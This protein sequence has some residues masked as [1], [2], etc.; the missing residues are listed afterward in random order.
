MATEMFLLYLFTRLDN[1]KEIS[2]VFLVICAV[3]LVGSF[4]VM[5]INNPDQ[6][7]SRSE[8]RDHE[9]AKRMFNSMKPWFFALLF[10]V[11]FVPNQKAAM[12]IVAGTGVIEAAKTDT[13]QRIATK[14]VGVVEKYLDEMLNDTKKDDKK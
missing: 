7:Y 13:A 8:K 3:L 12:F 2:G 1:I 14:S 4:I 11:M 6:D 9:Q 5:T 10:I